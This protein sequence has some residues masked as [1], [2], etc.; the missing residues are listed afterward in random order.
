MTSRSVTPSGST[1]SPAISSTRRDDDRLRVFGHESV[2]EQ[3]LRQ[4]GREV[5]AVVLPLEPLAPAAEESHLPGDQLV[6][7]RALEAA[8]IAVEHPA[9]PAG[10]AGE[11][12]DRPV[13]LGDLAF[14]QLLG[15][16]AAELRVVRGE[17]VVCVHGYTL[18]DNSFA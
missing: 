5:V 3:P 10:A 11:A 13:A 14:G 2:C 12:R 8:Q 9:L 15:H 17:Q 4:V 18:L 1:G 6:E 7:R 16:A